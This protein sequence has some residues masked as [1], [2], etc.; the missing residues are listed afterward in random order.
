MA[1]EGPAN[2]AF[3]SREL[4]WIVFDTP[5]QQIEFVEK[6]HAQTEP[7]VFVPDGGGLNVEFRMS[8]SDCGGT[9]SRRA[10]RRINDPATCVRYPSGSPSRID[11]LGDLPGTPPGILE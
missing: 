5:E 6:T 7:L 4:Q 1:E 9:T 2:L 3:H 10:I 11:R 8:S